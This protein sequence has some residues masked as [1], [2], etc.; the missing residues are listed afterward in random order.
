MS[1]NTPLPLRESKKAK[2]QNA[3]EQIHHQA[4]QL[5]LLLEDS[6]LVNKDAP[7]SIQLREGID[8]LK[9]KYP[10]VA[11]EVLFFLALLH[12]NR[13]KISSFEKLL[14]EDL[15]DQLNIVIITNDATDDQYNLIYDLQWEVLEKFSEILIDFRLI[16]RCNTPL[17]ELTTFGDSIVTLA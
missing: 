7:L 17:E 2:V 4:S 11:Q 12:E 6:Y 15:G 13:D 5:M 1:T 9:Q 10:N 16:E 14:Y 3:L 8:S